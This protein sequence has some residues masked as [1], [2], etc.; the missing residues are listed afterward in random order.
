MRKPRDFLKSRGVSFI[1]FILSDMTQ[2][3]EIRALIEG[4]ADDERVEV[5]VALLRA[6]VGENGNDSVE[7]LL[8]T[9]QVADVLG[10]SRPFVVKLIDGGQLPAR[11]VGTHRRVRADDL[12]TW[13]AENRRQ[14]LDVLSEL[15]RL[16]RELGL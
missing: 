1:S 4:K 3:K 16:D 8:S 5:S 13:K 14:R 9:Q 11:L 2:Q 7:K 10:V 6:L 12:E 15:A